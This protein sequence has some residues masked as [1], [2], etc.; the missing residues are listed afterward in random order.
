MKLERLVTAHGALTSFDFDAGRGRSGRRRRRRL[1]RARIGCRRRRGSRRRVDKVVVVNV[2]HLDLRR[3]RRRRDGHSLVKR[4]VMPG[5]EP[6]SAHLVMMVTHGNERL[7]M[8]DL[9]LVNRRSVRR[10]QVTETRVIQMMR[11][12]RRTH[13][14]H[15]L[16]VVVV[17]EHLLVS[18][19]LAARVQALGRRRVLGRL[20]LVVVKR[21]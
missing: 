18:R 3:I 16:V 1:R 21:R 5:R 20:R 11:R 7:L 12:R 13:R 17:V 6:M 19:L 9:V 8:R 4:V 10:V 15:R 14:A 2:E